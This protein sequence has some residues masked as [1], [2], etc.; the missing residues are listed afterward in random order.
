MEYLPQFS[1]PHRLLDDH[2]FDG[3]EFLLPG[4]GQAF[5]Q[6]IP[7]GVKHLLSYFIPQ[8]VGPGDTRISGQLIHDLIHHSLQRRFQVAV[9]F[10]AAGEPQTVCQVGHQLLDARVLIRPLLHAV[11]QFPHHRLGV[12]VQRIPPL[13]L[14][15]VEF[16]Q[17]LPEDL[18]C[19][20]GLDLGNPFF[21]QVAGPAIRAVADHVDVGMVG[22]VVEGG[23]PPE[24][25]PGDLH[26][27]GHLHGISGE[28]A[29]PPLRVIVR[30]PA[31]GK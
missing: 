20:T 31:A 30:P 21:C 10:F 3:L 28:Q 23:V 1:K 24:L 17:I 2:I 6:V 16:R 29:F 8:V 5:R 12:P 13:G 15:P 14:L 19:Q 4:E 9:L 11:D 7:V 18:S 22:L 26:G 27:L 25:L